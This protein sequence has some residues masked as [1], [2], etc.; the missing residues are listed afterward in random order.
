MRSDL[1][2][3]L[4]SA[5]Q[6]LQRRVAEGELPQRAINPFSRQPEHSRRIQRMLMSLRDQGALGDVTESDLSLLQDQLVGMGPLHPLVTDSS[7]ISIQVM[8]HDVVWVYRGGTWERV[9]VTW[10]T[11]EAL[12]QYAEVLAARTGTALDADRRVVSTNFADPDGR[13]QIDA[14]A[15]TTAGVTIHVRL[16]RTHRITLEQMLANGSMDEEMHR[17]LRGVARRDVGVLITGLPGTG[18]TTLLESLSSL[19]PAEPVVAL[20]DGSEFH[21]SHPFCTLYS[22]PSSELK[23]AFIDSLRKNSSRVAIAEVR[24]DE[25]AEILRYSGAVTVWTT[26]H[27]SVR[28]AMLRL[29]AL[30]VGSPDSPY[31][32]LAQGTA[33]ERML[34]KV[35]ASAF[36]VIIETDKMIVGGATRFY[37]G[38]I[39]HLNEDGEIYPLFEAQTE[40]PILSGFAKVGD[41]DQILA[42]YRQ[43]VWMNVEM[44]TL[45]SIHAALEISDRAALA[46]LGEYLVQ[47]PGANAGY[48]VLESLRRKSAGIAGVIENAVR[49]L[50]GTVERGLR[51]RNWRL[52]LEQ[53]AAIDSDPVLSATTKPLMEKLRSH[54][55][56]AEELRRRARAVAI[57]EEVLGIEP[58]MRQAAALVGLREKVNAEPQVYP[59]GTLARVEARLR[60]MRGGLHGPIHLRESAAWPQPAQG[61]ELNA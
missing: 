45:N 7:V 52:L 12:R 14:T 28:N 59:T 42:D 10:E 15:R 17:F 30:A 8:S 29:M 49:D 40:G 43:R 37:I 38:R 9:D 22:V 11:P 50:K 58:T 48:D 25:A 24:G 46:A 16:G 47:H 55:L 41:P 2:A 3:A 1:Q 36:P 6:S 32:A 34:Q 26:V 61:E 21:P 33:G 20:D 57:A 23:Q 18:K 53:V 35:I 54:G 5:S 13:I 51:T 56:A 31:T 39:A 4:R 19:W 60:Y 44:P 27:G